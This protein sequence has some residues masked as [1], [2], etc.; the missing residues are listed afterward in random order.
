MITEL[1]IGFLLQDLSIEESKLV[2][3]GV[4]GYSRTQHAEW[5][6]E[7]ILPVSGHCHLEQI[8]SKTVFTSIVGHR[9]DK[10]P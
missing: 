2:L 5:Y 3:L 10:I 7:G 4:L 6:D 1:K 9:E 8:I